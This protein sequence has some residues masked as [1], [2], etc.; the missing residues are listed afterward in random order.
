MLCHLLI[1]IIYKMQNNA[2]VGLLFSLGGASRAVNNADD[3][4]H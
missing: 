2:Y 4:V 1:K 3:T